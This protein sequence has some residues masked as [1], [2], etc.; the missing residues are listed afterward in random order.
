[1]E[2]IVKLTLIVEGDT[3]KVFVPFLRDFLKPRL[4]ASMPETGHM[5][6]N[7]R[8]PTGDDLAPRGAPA[9]WAERSR[10]VI[11]LTDV[12]PARHRLTSRMQLTR[13]RKWRKWVGDE[14]GFTP[15]RP[16]YDF[17]AWLLP[18]WRRSRSSRSTTG[19]HLGPPG[20]RQPQQS[21]AHRLKKLFEMVS[22]GTAM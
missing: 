6:Y 18:Y 11:A 5:P 19:M 21:A 2:P 12:Y 13:S 10:P 4:A 9:E 3:E 1:L 8:I 22:A 15:M 14:P 17:E 16:Q 7:G 20:T